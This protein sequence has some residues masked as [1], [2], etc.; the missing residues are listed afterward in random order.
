LTIPLIRHLYG[1]GLV[2]RPDR[3]EDRPQPS[4]WLSILLQNSRARDPRLVLSRPEQRQDSLREVEGIGASGSDFEGYV[5]VP[6]LM[7]TTARVFWPIEQLARL[8]APEL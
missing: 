2:H 5:A 4:A 7:S 8:L 3:L 6:R 1:C